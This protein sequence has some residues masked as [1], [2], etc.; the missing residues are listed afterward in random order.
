MY[1]EIKCTIFLFLFHFLQFI[2][3]VPMYTDAERSFS[4]TI[5]AERLFSNMFTVK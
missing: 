2:S 4:G 3:V 5:T 1:V